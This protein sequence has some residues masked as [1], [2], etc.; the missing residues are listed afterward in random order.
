FCGRLELLQADE[1]GNSVCHVTL[2]DVTQY[3]RAEVA[4]RENQ[5]R[6]LQYE[7]G[8]RLRLAFDAGELGAWDHDFRT[9]NIACSDRASAMLGFGPSSP[10][11]WP[12]FLKRLHEEDRACFLQ[13][14]NASTQPRGSGRFD[15]VFR[16]VLPDGGLRWLRFV[17]QSFF[18]PAQ[19]GKAIRRAGVLADITRQKQAEEMLESRAMHLDV[20]VRERTAQLQEALAELEYFSYTLAHDLRAPLRA[21]RGFG[22]LLLAQCKNL[23]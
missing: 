9:G 11:T 14:A 3:K 13:A 12:T 23:S 18:D 7:S 4:L 17:A 2:S 21:I 5:R 6:Q 1:E 22:D 10:V 8:E 15:A 16:V 20:L 19:T